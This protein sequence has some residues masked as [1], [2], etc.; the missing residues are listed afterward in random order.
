MDFLQMSHN[1]PNQSNDT[2]GSR[3]LFLQWLIQRLKSAIRPKE[4][5][6]AL[7]RAL[8]NRRDVEMGSDTMLL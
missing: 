1:F 7:A 3:C 6:M 5:Q 4:K 2:Q 8:W